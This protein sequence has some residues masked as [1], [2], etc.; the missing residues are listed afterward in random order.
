MSVA[1]YVVL[2]VITLGVNVAAF[3]NEAPQAAG[4]EQDAW[5]IA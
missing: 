5:E 1:R 3:G 2:A 4:A